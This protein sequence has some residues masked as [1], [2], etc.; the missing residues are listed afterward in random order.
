MK[1]IQVIDGATNTEYAVYA[2]T[3]EQFAL[4]FPGKGQNVEFVEDLSE[5]LGDDGM[6]RALAHV[7][8][9]R[10]AKPE[11]CGLHG[12]LFYQMR[13]KRK[14]YPK[15]NDIEM[16]LARYPGFYDEKALFPPEPPEASSASENV[17]LWDGLKNLQVI[18]TA[19]YSDYAIFA[20]TEEQFSAVFPVDGQ[21]EAFIEEV[22]KRLGR[23]RLGGVLRQV[24]T[25]KMGKPRVRRIDGTLFYGLRPIKKKFFSFSGLKN[26][27]V[28]D[29][30]MN[31]DYAVFAVTD[32]EF[33]LFF[34]QDRQ[35]IEFSEDLIDRGGTDAFNALMNAI[36]NRRVHK[37]T[38]SGIHGTMFCGLRS[39]KREFYPTKIDTEIRT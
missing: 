27:Q 9:R 4:I 23:R 36:R 30:S 38:V 18:D 29:S 13:W 21:R 25:R 7:W 14:Y 16:G 34:P 12:T 10:V 24:W 3:E 19:E 39:H 32:V 8:D 22:L 11:V 2:V 15:L 26:I 37:P 33:G 6:D 17:M 20:M 1:N 5:R 31:A 28:I 35:N